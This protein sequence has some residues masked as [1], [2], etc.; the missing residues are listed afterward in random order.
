MPSPGEDSGQPAEEGQECPWR[1]DPLLMLGE[2][3]TG[4]EILS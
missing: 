1:R 4:G 2:K 3:Q